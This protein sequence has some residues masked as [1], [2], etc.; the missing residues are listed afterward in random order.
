MPLVTVTMHKG[1]SADRKTGILNA[2]H[3]ALVNSGVPATDRFQRMIELE[4]ENFVYDLQY[5]DLEAPRTNNF[6]I[7]E[8]T[9]SAGRSVK[10]KRKILED[11]MQLLTAINVSPNDIMVHF[12][13]TA[14]ENW[15]FANGKQIHV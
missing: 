14:W 15:A 7:I 4:P 5:P 3:T 1:H 6:T 13:E 2:V 11:L 9:L 12:Q 8:I 10:V